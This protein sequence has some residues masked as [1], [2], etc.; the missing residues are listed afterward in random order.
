MLFAI[1]Y[2]LRN[3]KNL[4]NT[5]LGAVLLLVKVQASGYNFTI[6][7]FP[8]GYFLR[9]LNC[10][11]GTKLCRASHMF[12]V[13][14]FRA[15][16]LFLNPQKTWEY[17]WFPGIFQE[18]WKETTSMQWVK[19]KIFWDIY[20]RT[21][22]GSQTLEGQVPYRAII[23]LTKWKSH[24]TV[25][26]AV[27][28]SSRVRGKARAVLQIAVIQRPK[29]LEIKLLT[30]LVSSFVHVI[31]TSWRE[32]CSSSTFNKWKKSTL[33]WLKVI[34]WRRMPPLPPPSPLPQ[35]QLP[36]ICR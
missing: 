30:K 20:L 9:F 15:T 8:H 34:G 10:S 11:N 4:K 21:L 27:N 18:I 23:V 6:N 12:K 17:L 33:T 19:D 28:L 7:R 13:N 1:W 25:G 24:R 2:Q 35:F 26:G 29:W 32:G 36:C 31:L 3:F 22:R 16:G 5:F 14:P